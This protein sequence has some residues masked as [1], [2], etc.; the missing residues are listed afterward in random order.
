MNRPETIQEVKNLL[1]PA[2]AALLSDDDIGR[3]VDDSLTVDSEGRAPGDVGYVDTYD[4]W[5]AAAE[6][7]DLLAIRAAG[8]AGVTEFTSEGSTFKKT[9]ADFS[10]MALGFRRKSPL[11]PL[12]LGLG[13]ID[14]TLDPEY[15]PRSDYD[16]G[17]PGIVGNWS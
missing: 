3:A 8:T 7:A 11:S 2:V 6:A 14:I 10:G 9:A 5:W 1:G 13:V 12:Y 15:R 4:P 17:L 16:R